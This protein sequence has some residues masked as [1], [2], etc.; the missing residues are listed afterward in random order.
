ME[1]RLVESSNTES[2]CAMLVIL[3]ECADLT[4]NGPYLIEHVLKHRCNTS[5]VCAQL[6]TSLLMACTRLFLRRPAE[7][8]Y[9]LGHV[10]ELC[11]NS[12]DADVHDK[13]AMYYVLLSTDVQLATSAILSSSTSTNS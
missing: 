9:V 11:M 10:F 3:G 1:S 4:D 13:A 8:Q 6:W 2:L 7:Y 5:P 12:P